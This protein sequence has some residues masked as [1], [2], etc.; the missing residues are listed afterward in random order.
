MTKLIGI[1]EHFVTADI[2]A[3]RAASPEGTAQD[4]NADTSQRLTL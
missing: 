4:A 1:E 3:A 2:R